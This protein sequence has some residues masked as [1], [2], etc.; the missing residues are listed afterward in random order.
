MC[1]FGKLHRF[2]AGLNGQKRVQNLD[3]SSNCDWCH[4]DLGE[5]MTI[6]IP[7][8]IGSRMC[9]ADLSAP[10]HTNELELLTARTFKRGMEPGRHAQAQPRDYTGDLL[11]CIVT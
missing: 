2:R 11:I 1:N 9:D 5:K 6:N 3:F 7:S 10:L 4:F 8:I